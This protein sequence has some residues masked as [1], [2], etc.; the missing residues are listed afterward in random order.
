MANKL[1]HDGADG[2]NGHVFHISKSMSD[3]RQILVVDDSESIREFVSLSLQDHG[4]EVTTASN[5][6]DAVS[7]LDG[8]AFDLLV[9]DLNMPEMDGI[10][11]IQKVRESNGYLAMPVLVITTET[12]LAK[13]NQAKAAGATG[14]IVK[15]FDAEQLLEV[16]KKVIR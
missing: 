12:Q 11:L 5:G 15:P 16:V 2:T 1:G 3:K 10:G 6:L 7:K 13:R 4:F 9:T 8:R 14:W